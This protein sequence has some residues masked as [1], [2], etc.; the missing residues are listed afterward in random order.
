MGDYVDAYELKLEDIISHGMIP[1]IRKRDILR[2]RVM[3]ADEKRSIQHG[4]PDMVAVTPSGQQL[5][6]KRSDIRGRYTYL[7][8]KKINLAGWSYSNTYMIIR[9]DHTRAFAMMIPTNCTVRL[10][11]RMA[12][13][14]GRS[15]ADYIVALESA[16]GDIDRETL[17]IIPSA[18]F[19]KMYTIPNN[20]VIQ[21]NKGKG[22]KLFGL[23]PGGDDERGGE[24]PSWFSKNTLRNNIQMPVRNRNTSELPQSQ[25]IG[26]PVQ[27]ASSTLNFADEL[28]MDTRLDFG[29]EDLHKQPMSGQLAG[30]GT[31][32]MTGMNSA[33][34]NALKRQAQQKYQKPQQP[35]ANQVTN[36]EYIAVGRLVSQQG[37]LVGF[38]IQNRSGRQKRLTLNQVINLCKQK[39]VSNIMLVRQENGRLS[40]RGNNIQIGNLPSYTV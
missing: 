3:T 10:G 26:R 12:N 32:V 17:G 31:G 11:N 4:A 5:V 35:Q 34:A 13:K 18:L 36:Y 15:G 28:G 20:E 33:A 6:L 24:I 9:G 37:Q 29:D 2:V 30:S 40:L 16:S 22:H 14:S 38:L 25:N 21:R 39:K 7:S 19:K 23:G 27:P 1:V 8:G